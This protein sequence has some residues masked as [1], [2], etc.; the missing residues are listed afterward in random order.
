MYW[1]Y[2]ADPDQIDRVIRELDATIDQLDRLWARIEQITLPSWLFERL[3][4][5]RGVTYRGKKVA[6]NA[7]DTV[8]V[9]YSLGSFEA[10]FEMRGWVVLV[11]AGTALARQPW[12]LGLA[13]FLTT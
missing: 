8:V 1:H 7:S 11:I 10:R 12:F 13:E 3:V 5:G 6:A 2:Q 9:R 4:P